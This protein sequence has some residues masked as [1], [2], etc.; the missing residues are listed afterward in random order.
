M[1]PIETIRKFRLKR[2]RREQKAVL[3]NVFELFA[4]PQ[5]NSKEKHVDNF[6]TLKAAKREGYKLKDRC[7]FI[8]I[9]QQR[10]TD[11]LITHSWVLTRDDTPGTPREWRKVW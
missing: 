7:R 4:R 3:L 8:H 6:T 10:Y 1:Q 11:K 2:G 5:I 9:H